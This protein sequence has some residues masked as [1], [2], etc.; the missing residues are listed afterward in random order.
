LEGAF[1]DL[2]YPSASNECCDCRKYVRA[3]GGLPASERGIAGSPVHRGNST[4]SEESNNAAGEIT[5]SF[6]GTFFP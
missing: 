2:G 4:T 6:I 1:M 5:G 3:T